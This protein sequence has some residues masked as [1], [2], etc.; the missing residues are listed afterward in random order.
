M[1]RF[2]YIEHL[3]ALAAIPILVVLFVLMWVA[4]KRAI[5]RFGD[6][7]L[8]KQLI[9]QMSKYKDAFKFGLLILGSKYFPI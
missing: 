4:R 1:F 6:L 8:M 7:G 3:Y 5:E 2:E 9:P